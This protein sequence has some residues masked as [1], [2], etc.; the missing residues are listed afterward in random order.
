MMR[1][2][3]EGGALISIDIKGDK[4]I[5]ALIKRAGSKAKNLKKPLKQACVLMIGSIDKNFRA[6]GR[7]KKWAKLA[8]MTIAMRRKKGKGAKILQDKGGLKGSFAYK[9]TSNQQAYVGTKA[10]FAGLHQHGGTIRIPARDIYPV[11]ASVLH[12]VI[13][14]RDVF[15][16]Y[17]HQKARSVTIPARPFLLFQDEDRRNIVSIFRGYLG[18][19][20]R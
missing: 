9:V 15:A 17:V 18:E 5:Q 19:I 16:K 1:L 6:E 14:G 10:K 2:M 13:G 7:P 12:F 11:K 3:A 20:I 8:P 4:E